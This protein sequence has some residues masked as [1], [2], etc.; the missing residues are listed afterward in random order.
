M[1]HRFLITSTDLAFCSRFIAWIHSKDNVVKP[2][3]TTLTILDEDP[4]EDRDRFRQSLRQ[5]LKTISEERVKLEAAIDGDT[6]VEIED[7]YDDEIY[8]YGKVVGLNRAFVI[9]SE[10]MES[11]GLGPESRVPA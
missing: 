3:S 2:E 10:L 9:L 5:A 11:V 1:T 8:L 6:S 7:D 4:R